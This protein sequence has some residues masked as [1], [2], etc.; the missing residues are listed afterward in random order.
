MIFNDTCHWLDIV[1]EDFEPYLDGAASTGLNACF[2]NTPLVIAYNLTSKVS[3]Q[4]D[5]DEQLKE[6]RSA[7]FDEKFGAVTAPL[8]DMSSELKKLTNITVDGFADGMNIAGSKE[9]GPEFKQACPF[10]LDFMSKDNYETMLTEPWKAA[11]H[12]ASYPDTT[13]VGRADL[14]KISLAR[15]GAETRLQW[16]DRVTNIAGYNPASNTPWCNSGTACKFG[17]EK[18]VKNLRLV[19][20]KNI[21]DTEDLQ[22]RMLIDLGVEYNEGNCPTARKDDNE[23]WDYDDYDCTKPSKAMSDLGTKKTVKGGVDSYKTKLKGTFT[24][25]LDL[26]ATAVGAI[27][28][29][30]EKFLC[31]MKCGFVGQVYENVH[32]EL[33]RTLL[34]GLIQISLS[35]WLLAFFMFLVSALGA[36]LVVRMRGVSKE[37]ANNNNQ[38]VEM[39]GVTLDLYS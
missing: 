15:N 38:G 20:D 28:V 16:F 11:K 8:K 39:K 25:V 4:E 17:C 12:Y 26:T 13:Y 37:E 6:L 1:V 9:Y 34:G 7:D 18:I 32:G 3:F 33:C 5:I 29:E 36:L 31:N 27:M 10:D 35:L 22:I 30:V 21:T 24:S 23:G 2:N 19:Y 14:Q